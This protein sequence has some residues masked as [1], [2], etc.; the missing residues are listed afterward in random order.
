MHSTAAVNVVKLW[1]LL[2][3]LCVHA[4][5]S[6]G[7]TE[8]LI[9]LL[10]LGSY[11]SQHLPESHTSFKDDMKFLDPFIRVN[12]ANSEPEHRMT[13]HCC[14]VDVGDFEVAQHSRASCIEHRA[15]L[16][17]IICRATCGRLWSGLEWSGSGVV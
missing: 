17:L 9:M 4:R 2:S 13:R 3:M 1:I 11:D 10:A 5:G 7:I 6:S 12:P 8:I 15:W 16:G 14:I